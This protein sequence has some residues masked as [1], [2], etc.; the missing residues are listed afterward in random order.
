VLELRLAPLTLRKV[1]GTL[2]LAGSRIVMRSAQAELARGA[3]RGDFAVRFA[4]PPEYEFAGTL[5]RVNLAELAAASAAWKGR[6]TGVA[7]GGLEL[8]AR[9][10]TRA[11][12]A[13]SLTLS[14]EFAVRDGDVRAADFDAWAAGEQRGGRNSFRE[15]R[16]KFRLA[17]GI[18]TLNPLEVR[19]TKQAWCI[20]GTVRVP[21]ALDL[22]LAPRARAAGSCADAS[23]PSSGDATRRLRGTLAEVSAPPAKAP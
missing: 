20:T 22:A 11:A 2:A 23:T 8:A 16:G 9:G 15:A 3:A 7:S 10:D 19:G 21:D 5:E 14:G 6:V 1:R 17:E 13:Q 18:V 4:T 12:L